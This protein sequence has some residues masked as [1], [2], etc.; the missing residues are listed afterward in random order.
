MEIKSLKYMFHSSRFWQYL[1]IMVLANYFGGFFSYSYKTFGENDSPHDQIS[2]TTLT[3]AASIGAGFVNGASRVVFGA[4]VDKYSFRCL[5]SILMAIQLANS[6]LCFWAAYVPWLFFICVLVNYMVIGGMYAIF[7][8]SVQNCFGLELGPQIYAQILIGG[9]F[10]SLL[11]LGTT[12]W[13]L[14]ATNFVTLFYVGSLFQIA[15][16]VCLYFF[17]E[18]LDVKN[19]AKRDCLKLVKSA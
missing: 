14:P 19:L 7:P 9:F 5:M 3:W 2:D 15:T 4:L 11:V 13:L 12:T 1:T 8:S 16:L 6:M 10:S 18:E 17:N